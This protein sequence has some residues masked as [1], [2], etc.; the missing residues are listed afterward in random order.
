MFTKYQGL[1]YFILLSFNFC[2]APF[3][4]H[5]FSPNPRLLVPLVS[6]ATDQPSVAVLS[7]LL[8][9]RPGKRCRKM[10]FQSEYNFRPQLKTWLFKTSV[11][12]III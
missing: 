11:P 6:Q 10:S 4:G 8:A 12:G 1:F 7:R 9:Q 2:G 5:P 3:S